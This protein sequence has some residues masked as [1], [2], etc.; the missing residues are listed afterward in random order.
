MRVVRNESSLTITVHESELQSAPAAVQFKGCTL[1]MYQSCKRRLSCPKNTTIS[2]HLSTLH[3][4]NINGVHT[5]CVKAGLFATE[6]SSRA[7]TVATGTTVSSTNLVARFLKRQGCNRRDED[8]D[9][10]KK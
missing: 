2:F 8:G 5:A 9:D 6:G 4:P 10:G 1:V 3:G 7:G